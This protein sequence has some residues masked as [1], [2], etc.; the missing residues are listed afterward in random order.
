[1]TGWFRELG[2]KIKLEVIDI[3]ALLSRVYNYV[4][5]TY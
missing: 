1:M 2:L 3:G 4:G 5:A